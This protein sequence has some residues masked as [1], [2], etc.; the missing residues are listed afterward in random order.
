M[1]AA[2]GYQLS[3]TMEELMRRAALLCVAAGVLATAGSAAAS[4][5]IIIAPT[6][7]EGCVSP[8][9]DTCTYTSTRDGGYAARGTTWTLTVEIPANG[10]PRDTNLD[11]K[12]RYV[13]NS[14]NAP[15]QGCGLWGAG[16]TVTTNGGADSTIAA[17]NP[18]PGASDA[19][20]GTA[21]D[22]TTGKIAAGNPNYTPVD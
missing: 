9:G 2:Q 10:D 22:C 8:S 11:G 16:A 17:G 6:G 14:S 3:D 12:L 19:V 21:N 4:D 13:F 1:S 7:Q 5:P 18:F 15:E 20:I